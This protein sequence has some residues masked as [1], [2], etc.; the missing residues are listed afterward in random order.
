MHPIK[1]FLEKRWG[2]FVI[3]VATKQSNLSAK[4]Y[5]LKYLH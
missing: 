3:A 1:A 2:K 5:H 4:E